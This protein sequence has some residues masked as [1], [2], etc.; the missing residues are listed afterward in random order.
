MNEAY[1]A[2]GVWDGL[3][4]QKA[5]A[6]VGTRPSYFKTRHPHHRWK[7]LLLPLGEGNIDEQAMRIVP[8]LNFSEVFLPIFTCFVKYIPS[9]TPPFPLASSSDTSLRSASSVYSLMGYS[10][11]YSVHWTGYL[12]YY[13]FLKAQCGFPQKVLCCKS[14]FPR[15][16][17]QV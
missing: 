4:R 8:K 14:T 2:A 9:G 1:G 17:N 15:Y 6:M 12:K 5:S 13:H 11:D 3:P 10:R 16:F 7:E